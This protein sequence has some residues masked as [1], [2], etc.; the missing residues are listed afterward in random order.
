VSSAIVLLGGLAAI[1]ML[2]TTRWRRPLIATAVTVPPPATRVATAVT[3]PAPPALRALQVA[4]VAAHAE[5][6]QG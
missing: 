6:D 4:A 1:A 5:A 3:V 2:D